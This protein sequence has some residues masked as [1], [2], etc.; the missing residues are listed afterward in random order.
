MDAEVG[1]AL[2]WER[3]GMRAAL[4]LVQ[5]LL[6]HAPD[7]REIDVNPAT[8]TSL[9][10]AGPDDRSDKHLVK[11]VRCMISLADGKF[12]NVVETCESVRRMVREEV[13]RR[14]R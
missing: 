1:E 12:V 3:M 6:L 8:I 13:E 5:L 2:E 14:A 10:E 9:R 4:A 7:G 11:G